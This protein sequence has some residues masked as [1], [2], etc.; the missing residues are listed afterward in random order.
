MTY[1]IS[2]IIIVILKYISD[3]SINEPSLMSLDS[4]YK[5]SDIKIDTNSIISEFA[6]SVP[7][8]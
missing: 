2:N 1:I 7:N 6:I 5:P 8:V 3:R 4:V